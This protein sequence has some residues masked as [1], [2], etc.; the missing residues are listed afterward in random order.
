MLEIINTLDK[1]TPTQFGVN[2]HMEYTWSTNIQEKIMQFSFQC[3]RSNEKGVAVLKE[4]LKELL[5]QMNFTK[6]VVYYLEILYRMIGYTRDIVFGKG[7]YTL[8]YMMIDAWYDFY[9]DLAIHA[10][11][12]LVKST[13]DTIQPYGSWK[14]MKYF[15]HYCINNGRTLFH[16]L[17]QHVIVLLNEQLKLDSINL[18]MDKKNNI[19]LVSKWIPREDSKFNWLYPMLATHYFIDFLK[20]AKTPM[21]RIKATIKC[22]TKYRQLLS[23][24]NKHVDTIQIKQCDKKWG[25]IDFSKVT[26]ITLNNQKKAFLNVRQNG[27][28]KCPVD[29]D[30]MNCA[31]NFQLYIESSI[32]NNDQIKGQRIDME[33]FTKTALDII[34]RKQKHDNDLTI[35]KK[36]IQYEIELLNSQ[37]RNHSIQNT[38]LSNFIAMI[39]VSH[40]MFGTPIHVANAIG[41]RIAE[42]SKLGK[43]VMTF[44]NK[45]EWINLEN[46][47]DDFVSMTEKICT[48]CGLNS[49]L[50]AALD[51][52]LNAIIDSKLTPAEVKDLVLVILSDMQVND[53]NELNKNNKI[54]YDTIQS[55]F[56]ETG[57]RLYNKPFQVPHIVFWNL[58]NTSGFP[59][60]SYQH[61]TS[62]VSGYSPLL[63]NTFCENGM[64]AITNLYTPWSCLEKIL[65]N[66]RYN[67]MG[68]KITQINYTN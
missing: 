52:I 47:S 11:T 65:M 50:Y 29:Q 67:I 54:L 39:D 4:K 16:P 7:E 9:P 68:D 26:S 22:K 31:L 24:L 14:D 42:K 8:T 61:N 15:C 58:K 64:K 12:C 20:T 49:N 27:T 51:L 36:S 66:E 46:C 40:S 3:N 5:S 38:T 35:D 28:I 34:R 37:W 23:T 63:L 44:S 62:M 45:P 56:N 53:V 2:A 18:N 33:M 41:I 17:I 55:K 10:L 6:H 43:R 59:C 57:I 1:L 32:K 48:N 13:D 21:S 30:R 25:T 19:S 60:L